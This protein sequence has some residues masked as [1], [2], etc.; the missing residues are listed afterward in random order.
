[1]IEHGTVIKENGVSVRVLFVSGQT[2]LVPKTGLG[3]ERL[4]M[5]DGVR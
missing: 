5:T 4:A 1:V 2:R 3:M